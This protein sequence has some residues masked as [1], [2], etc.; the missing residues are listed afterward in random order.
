LLF[1]LAAAE[2]LRR[3]VIAELL[4]SPVRGG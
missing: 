3:Q 2:V 1:G 4:P